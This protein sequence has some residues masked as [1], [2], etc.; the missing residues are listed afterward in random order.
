MIWLAIVSL[1]A[2]G[3]LARHF[4]IIV[5]VPATLVIVAIAIAVG[6]LRTTDIWSIALII[7]IPSVGIQVG[8]FFGVLIQYGLSAL[9]ARGPSPSSEKRTGRTPWVS[10]TPISR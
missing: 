1:V 3:L 5:L 8:Y 2:G 10:R 4:K 6:E 9:M 7:A